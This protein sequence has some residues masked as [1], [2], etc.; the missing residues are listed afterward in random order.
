[1]SNQFKKCLNQLTCPLVIINGSIVLYTC[2]YF[3]ILATLTGVQLYGIVVL[4]YISMINNELFCMLIGH[5]YI[6][7]CEMSL[8]S[9]AYC[10][11]AL[12]FSY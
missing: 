5:L 3:F 8:H 10:F 1:M 6:P 7:F 11:V 9:S 12:S 2:Q 4:I